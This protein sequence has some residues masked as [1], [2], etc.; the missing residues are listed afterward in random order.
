[1]GAQ[2]YLFARAYAVTLAASSA[3]TGL[4][5][6]NLD[7]AQ[8]A[9]RVRFEVK[10]GVKD[11]PNSA[12][13][14]LFNLSQYSRTGLCA[15]PGRTTRIKL[16][17]GYQGLVDTLFFGSASK[18]TTK[19][20]GPDITTEIEAT[21]GQDALLNTAFNQKYLR[22]TPLTAILS[23]VR[24]AMNVELGVVLGLPAGYTLARSQTLSGGCRQVLTACLRRHGLEFNILNNKLNILPRGRHLGK[25]AVVVSPQAG[26]LG[27]PSI[28]TEGVSFDSLLN[29][30][31]VPGQ[32]VQ[33]ISH[34]A[35]ATGF[36]KLRAASFTG[37]SHGDDWKVFCECARL[38]A[39]QA[40]ALGPITN[41]AFGAATN[42][43]LL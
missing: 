39:G 27:V 40:Q 23:D 42:P 14:T 11:T 36:Y 35:T 41:L 15:E 33:L 4:Q 13:I 34:N 6:G 1:M 19:R 22:H 5:Y 25:A 29:P 3:Q 20:D 43:N 12:K 26:M 24:R 2:Q 18:I 30:K 31:L 7:A 8:S 9:L 16:Q 28:S 10:Q 32:L 21:D 17:A 38:P 37:D